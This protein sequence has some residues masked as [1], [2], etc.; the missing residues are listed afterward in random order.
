MPRPHRS[1][2]PD[3]ARADTADALVHLLSRGP[4][5]PSCETQRGFHHAAASACQRDRTKKIVVVLSDTRQATHDGLLHMSSL[6]ENEDFSPERRRLLQLLAASAALATGACS[7]PPPEPIVPFVRAPEEELPGK[8]LFYA[9]SVLLCGHAMGV[10]VETNGGRPTKVEGNPLHPASLGS[11]DMF[12]QAAVLQ[13]WDPAR[14]QALLYQTRLTTWLHFSS[15]MQT[16]RHEL[17][18][19]Q[20]AGLFVLTR[21]TSSPTLQSQ[22]NELLK[23]Y[24]RASLHQYDPLHRD[25]ELRGS[26]LAFGRSLATRY[27]LDKARVLLSLDGDALS[28]AP[29]SVR[30][31]RDLAQLRNPERGRMSRIFALESSPGLLGAKADH[32]LALTPAAIRQFVTHLARALGVD[33]GAN[34]AAS[35]APGFERAVVEDLKANQGGC[36][37][38]PNTQLDPDMHALVHTLNHRLQGLGQ[39]F[40]HI[41]PIIPRTASD[42]E[43]I[44]SLTLAMAQGRVRT[45]LILDG[46]PAYDAPA[47]L[48]FA[49]HLKRVPESIHLGLYV[50]ETSVNCTWHLPQAHEFEQWSDARAYDGTASII[51]PVIAPLYGGRSAHEILNVFLGHPATTAYDTVR[52]YWEQTL[53]LQETQER[54]QAALRDGVIAGTAAAAVV[55]SPRTP[56]LSPEP[57]PPALTANFVPDQSAL[58]GQFATNSW[59]QEIPRSVSKLTW[60]NAAYLS[61]HTAASLQVTTGDRIEIRHGARAIR[62]SVYVT[63]S[64]AD[65]SVT[66]PLGYGRTHAGPVGTGVGFN[67]YELRTMDAPWH[68]PIE[69]RRTGERW[70]L[71]TTQDHA[72]MEGRHIVRSASLEE[73][74]RNPTFATAAAQ[75]RIPDHTLY[76]D[77]PH[78]SYQWGMVIDLNACIGS[79]AC[80]IASHAE[81]NIP[82]VGKKEVQHKREKH[83]NRN[84]HKNEKEPGDDSGAVD[85]LFQPVPCMHCERAPCELVCP[86]EATTHASQGLNLQVYNRCV[87][88][89]FC[90]NNCPY[91]VRR[92]NFLEYS[93]QFGEAFKAL[94]NPDVTVRQRGVMEKCTYCVQRIQRGK[95]E[96]QEL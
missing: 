39:T 35:P 73:F 10:L 40:D 18:E 32:R 59:L 23:L 37:K 48:E 58:D 86:V 1:N 21:A 63:P 15:A 92:F 70:S 12:A 14:A 24:P 87:G 47:D 72:R 80:T 6:K 4:W 68:A 79:N 38:K 30:Y 84:E 96:A 20:G 5:P 61:P 44:H 81:N 67:A 74:T 51:Q 29:S 85:I 36:H 45:L 54:W 91:K 19:S 43:S 16:R 33:A 17:N 69:V 64:H 77:Y 71:A 65:N 93:K 7:G 46:N 60:D 62:A 57:S 22:L 89:R 76:P 8:P 78:D 56:V 90:S 49:S 53:G 42:L 88:T 55:S 13:L 27:Y 25:H 66:L 34:D 28:G 2:A 50:D 31:A 41:D 3:R 95:I 11:T 52:S 75:D 94:H 9:T 82:V 26:E 83:K